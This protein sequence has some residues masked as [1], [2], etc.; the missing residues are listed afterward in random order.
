MAVDYFMKFDGAPGEVAELL[1]EK[2]IRVLSWGWTAH[3][4]SS[5][6]SGG[7]SGSGKVDFDDFSFVSDFDSSSNRFFRHICKG[8]HVPGAIL[9]ARK[10]GGKAWPWLEMKFKGVFVTG[11]QNQASWEIPAVSIAFSFEEV[12]I[13]Y[14]IQKSDGTATSTG[15]ITYN[16][17][18]NKLS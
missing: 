7:G 1:F 15:A 4:L 2:Q 18:E 12:S 9:T 5:V 13:E 6:G 16:R 8:T 10:A 14:R 17:K 11:V 3:A